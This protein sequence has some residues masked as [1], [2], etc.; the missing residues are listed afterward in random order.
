M[1]FKEFTPRLN[2][3]KDSASSLSST[4]PSTAAYLISAHNAIFHEDHKPLN[5][6]LHDSSCGACGSSRKTEW[7]KVASIKKSTR[8][9]VTSSLAKGLTTEGATVYKCLR[10]RRRTVTQS[11]IPSKSAPI[12]VKA[13]A[14]QLSASAPDQVS[15]TTTTKATENASSKKRAKA[16][17]QGGLQAL[18]ANKKSQGSQSQSKSLDLFD[19]LQ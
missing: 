18:L 1:H 15:T 2:F 10:C 7:A 19:F 6:R 9:H 8:R 17:K 4:S 5:E 3:L 16:R 12:P 14:S 13:T 11:R